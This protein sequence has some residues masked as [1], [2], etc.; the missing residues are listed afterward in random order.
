MNFQLSKFGVAFSSRA[1]GAAV[2]AAFDAARGANTSV[3]IDF[4]GVHAI[5]QS[6]TDE[7][8]GTLHQRNATS[9]PFVDFSFQ[10]VEPVLEHVLESVAARRAALVA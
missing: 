4:D 6:F 9:G 7:F 10:D 3:V 1:K 8:I 5:S 2:L